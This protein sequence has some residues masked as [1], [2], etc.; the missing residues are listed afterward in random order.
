MDRQNNFN[1]RAEGLQFI[2]STFSCLILKLKSPS[3]TSFGMYTSLLRST[4]LMIQTVQ[5]TG[6]IPLTYS[7]GTVLSVL[8]AK[9][10]VGTVLSADF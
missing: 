6:T 7:R 5:R 10:S 4:V 8:S 2:F 1:I 9:E 3:G